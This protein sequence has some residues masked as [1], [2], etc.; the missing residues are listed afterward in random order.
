[1]FDVAIVGAGELGGTL[2]SLLA[3]CDVARS[4]HLI[5]VKPQVAAGKA[6]DI[7]Q[8]TPILGFSTSVTGSAEINAAAGAGV[9]VLADSA[10]GAEWSLDDGAALLKR[11]AFGASGSVIVCAGAS[12]R[13]L[14]EHGVRVLKFPRTRLIGSAPEALAGALRALVALEVNG[15]PR[16]VALT[17]VGVPPEG[18]VVPW[19]DATI[20]GISASRVLDEPTRRRLAARVVPLWP[21]GA[22]ALAAAAAVV[23]TAI[24][25]RSRRRLSVFVGP[26]DSHGTKARAAAQPV[27]LDANGIAHVERL[28]LT[29]RDQVDFDNAVLL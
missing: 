25:G 24:L 19:G 8:S 2:A 14:V 4:V 11:L 20:G 27:R 29:G 17:V 6:L 22:N 21:P 7:A 3:G 16:D 18:A 1:M 10:S 13:A 28:P 9:V 26:D 23:L 15:S 12:H 5:D